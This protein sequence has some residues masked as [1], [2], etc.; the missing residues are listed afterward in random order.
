MTYEFGIEEYSSE[1][2][3]WFTQLR[4]YFE[5]YLSDLVIC[6]EHI[7][8]TAIPNMVAK[9]IIDMDI[10]IKEENFGEV[11]SKLEEIGYI[12]QGDLGIEE[13]EAFKL[14][15]EELKQS[16][17]PHHLYVCDDSSKELKRHIIFREFLKD[18]PKELNK[19][20]KIKNKL[21]KE[22]SNDKEA[23]IEGKD[24]AV[25]QILKKAMKEQDNV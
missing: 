14:I 12:H 10:V 1:W 17:P 4:K 22:F 13:R 5:S 24:F 18:N 6:I 11:K 2:K 15:N 7:G 23:Y 16:L 3:E 19:L 20:C 25:K 8:S 21:F 9:P